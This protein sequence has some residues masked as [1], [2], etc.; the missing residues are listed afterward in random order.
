MTKTVVDRQKVKCIK[1]VWLWCLKP[2]S[3]IVQLYRV[4][5]ATGEV[6]LKQHYVIKFV[7]DL[8]QVG[9]FLRV[10]RFPPPIT[11]TFHIRLQFTQESWNVI[12]VELC[13]LWGAQTINSLYIASGLLWSELS[14]D[15]NCVRLKFV[16]R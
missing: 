15:A 11:L 6:F 3:T 16:V 4:K 2:L 5:R 12:H 10:F 8:R 14:N 1:G 13:V 7:S 9:D